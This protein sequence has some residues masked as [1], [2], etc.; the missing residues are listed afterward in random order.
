M[1]VYAI[2]MALLHFDFKD[3]VDTVVNHLS[4][5]KWFTCLAQSLGI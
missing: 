2:K 1:S 5:Y 4:V 3:L